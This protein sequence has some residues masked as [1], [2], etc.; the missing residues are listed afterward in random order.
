L[1]NK[2]G[3]NKNAPAEL[4]AHA[5]K[6]EAEEQAAEAVAAAKRKKIRTRLK[7]KLIKENSELFNNK[8]LIKYYSLL[9]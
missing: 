7:N 1:R 8:E 4:R 6:I 9:L 3:V 2:L 5:D